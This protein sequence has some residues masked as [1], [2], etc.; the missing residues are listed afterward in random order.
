MKRYII[1]RNKKMWE[2]S[3]CILNVVLAR[4][5]THEGALH[6]ASYFESDQIPC[7]CNLKRKKACKACLNRYPSIKGYQP[8]K[9]VKK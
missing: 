8:M 1:E 4:S 9:D 3:D 5:H 6:I 7:K 2:V